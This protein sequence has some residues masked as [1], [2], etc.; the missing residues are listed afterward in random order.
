MVCQKA[1]LDQLSH[2]GLQSGENGFALL[3]MLAKLGAMLWDFQN[4]KKYAC[5]RCNHI[6]R[7]DKANFS[8]LEIKAEGFSNRSI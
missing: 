1:E 6:R 4:P 8:A 3:I 5:L 7:T 2:K